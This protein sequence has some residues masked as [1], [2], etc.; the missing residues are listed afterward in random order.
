MCLSCDAAGTSNLAPD[1]SVIRVPPLRSAVAGHPLAGGGSGDE[2]GIPYKPLEWQRRPRR[3]NMMNAGDEAELKE[4]QD[5]ET[6]EDLPDGGI[7]GPARSSRAIVSVAFSREDLRK[8]AEHARRQ[9]M[10]TSEFI[11]N[12]TLDATA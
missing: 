5:P 12:A 2:D 3:G 6:W 10:K 4:L 11:R 7:R 1:H 8:I 9:G